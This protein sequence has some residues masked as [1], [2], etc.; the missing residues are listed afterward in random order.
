MFRRAVLLLAFLAPAALVWAQPGADDAAQRLERW[1]A[2]PAR[3][4]QLRR[5]WRQFQLL[6]VERRDAIVRLD[7]ELHRLPPSERERLTNAL[8]RYADWLARLPEADR[9]RI[10]AAATKDERLALIRTLRDQQWMAKQPRAV[11]EQWAKLQGAARDAFVR[12]RRAEARQRKREWTIAAR[13]WKELESRRP[14][15]SRPADF[16]GEVRTYIQDYLK[17]MLN[18]DEKEQLAKAEGTWPGYPLTLVELA[19]RHPQALP[20]PHGPRTIAELPLPLQNRL[21][22]PKLGAF[23]ALRSREG[24]W[25][26]FAHELTRIAAKRG[27]APFPHELWPWN[28]K[29]LTAPMQTF[30]DRTL[31]PVLN[32]SEQTDLLHSEGKWPDFPLTIDRLARAHDLR[33]PWHTLPGAREKWDA[34]RL[35]RP[36][37]ARP[38]P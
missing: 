3:L 29:G 31:R 20:G 37:A 14:L 6:P 25:P 24:H 28:F 5:S 38:G 13:F 2:Q 17:P 19:D 11:R 12:A 33:P 8:E 10:A 30:V 26:Q 1:R 16:P 23:K 18:K 27:W 4:E 7:E 22:K 36:H 21:A 35:G 34:Y 15:P 9:A 32:A